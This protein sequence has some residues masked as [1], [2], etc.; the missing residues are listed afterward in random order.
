MWGETEGEREG[1]VK[2]PIFL[3]SPNISS[4]TEKLR[5]RADRIVTRNKFKVTKTKRIVR[6]VQA[7]EW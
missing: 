1:D 2:Y 4:K 3:D 7:T 5:F 6:F